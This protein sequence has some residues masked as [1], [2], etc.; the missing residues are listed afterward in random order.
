MGWGARLPFLNSS[1][2]DSA[3]ALFSLAIGYAMNTAKG[4][5]PDRL[6]VFVAD[7]GQGQAGM[8]AGRIRAALPTAQVVVRPEEASEAVDLVVLA[9]G[10]ACLPEDLTAGVERYGDLGPVLVVL[11]GGDDDL[12]LVA[13]SAGA[14]DWVAAAGFDPLALIHRVVLRHRA[15]ESARTNQARARLEGETDRLGRLLSGGS[16]S[17]TARSF[18]SATLRD[19]LPDLYISSLRRLNDLVDQAVEERIYGDGTNLDPELQS[20]AETLGF[21]RAG[22]RDVIDL[23]VTVLRAR[24]ASGP[25]RRRAVMMEESRLLVLQLMGHL[26]NHYRLRVMGAP[27]RRG[28]K[29]TQR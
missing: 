29:G 7:V 8:I 21:A 24:D 4:E 28:E 12:G 5:P 19:A 14:D 20:L 26:A 25:A 23:Y 6:Y 3:D 16:T 27:V 10:E 11:E 13:L 17:I 1:D 9:V 22:P 15:Q 2:R 18:G